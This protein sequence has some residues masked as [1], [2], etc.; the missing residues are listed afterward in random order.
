MGG[1]GGAGVGVKTFPLKLMLQSFGPFFSKK[2]FSPLAPPV[3]TFFWSKIH[4]CQTLRPVLTICSR[5]LS[6]AFEK[7]F[8]NHAVNIQEAFTK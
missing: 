1:E 2:T 4:L 3:A 8:L 5:S 6:D 7:I